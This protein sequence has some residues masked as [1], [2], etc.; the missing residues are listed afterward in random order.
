MINKNTFNK[1]LL[2]LKR[3]DFKA[4]NR[5]ITYFMFKFLGLVLALPIIIILWLLKPLFW[6]KV[7]K[8]HHGRIGH[9]ALETD[10][11]LRKRQLGIFSDEPFY[12]FVCDSR[13]VA[14][15]QLLAMYK[16]VMRIY[17]NRVFVSIFDGMF[18]ILKRTPFYQPLGL[19][20]NEYFE[21]NN[22]KP[23]IIFTPQEMQKG[24][25]LL[26]EMNVDM[27]KDNYVCIF[28]RDD[29]FL[30][31]NM[32]YTDWGYHN[33]RNSDINDFI[34]ASK[35]LIEKGLTVIRVGSVVNKPIAYSHPKLIDYSTS[36]IQCA[37][38]DIFLVGTS[39]FF[40]GSSSGIGDVALLFDV[41]RLNVNFAE[42]G[43]VPTGKNCLYIPKK[44]KFTKTGQYLHFREAFK[45]KLK[46]YSTNAHDLGLEFEDN[47]P[48]DILQVTQEMLSRLEGVFAYSA[49]E[50]KLIK[51]FQNLWS[52]SDVICKDVPTPIGIEW[53][54]KNKDLYF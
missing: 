23:S 36:K 15:R 27:D 4:I 20:N 49:E 50:K 40:L 17:E 33:Y 44:H 53:L 8:I 7:G 39:K 52:H 5:A 11:F 28:A 45:I 47:S 34:E 1:F 35:F 32:P 12:C 9:L 18:P 31:K 21:F 42:F 22:A 16:R 41:P 37:F 14:N 3:G 24:R 54:K 25:R 2:N 19:K 46:P 26:K 10:L 43:I 30:N 48:E 13:G 6:I 29:T 51:D 38:L